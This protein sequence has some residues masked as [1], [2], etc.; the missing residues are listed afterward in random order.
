MQAMLENF[1]NTEQTAE[2]IGCSDAHVR[3]ML[4]H[5]IMRGKKVCGRAWMVHRREADRIARLQ[6]RVGRPRRRKPA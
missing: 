2:V 6:H 3:Y 5:K 1:L 4:A